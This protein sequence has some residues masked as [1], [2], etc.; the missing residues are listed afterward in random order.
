[1]LYNIFELHT[2]KKCLEK[3]KEYKKYFLFQ[4]SQMQIS[5]L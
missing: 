3:L 5:Q 2:C 1:M 4:I